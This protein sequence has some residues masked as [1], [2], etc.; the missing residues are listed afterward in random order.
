MLF[1]SGPE[2]VPSVGELQDAIELIG[3]ARCVRALPTPAARTGA[4]IIE[5]NLV[6]TALSA[7]AHLLAGKAEEILPRLVEGLV[8]GP[9]FGI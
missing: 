8:E 7:H 3:R 2:F 5:I 6:P 4:E 1:D 9:A